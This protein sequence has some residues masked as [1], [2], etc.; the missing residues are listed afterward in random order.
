MEH[1]YDNEKE[2]INAARQSG[3]L[4]YRVRK[5]K[6]NKTFT[7][8]YYVGYDDKLPAYM[9]EQKDYTIQELEKVLQEQESDL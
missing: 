2:A 3:Y 8:R 1:W 5:H 6:Q 7:D 4:C 9:K